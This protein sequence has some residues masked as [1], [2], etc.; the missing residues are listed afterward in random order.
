[1]L[2]PRGPFRT[3]TEQSRE[4]GR[5]GFTLV[6]LVI[7][8]GILG[9][10]LTIAIPNFMKLTFKSR[11]AEAYHV[12]HGIAVAQSA[13]HTEH[14][15]YAGTFDQLGTQVEGGQQLDPTTIQGPYYTYTLTG[16]TLSGVDN[17][18]YRV[19]AT[20]DIDPEDPVLD[21]IIIENQLTVIQ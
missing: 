19:T 21:V 18:N 10:I 12:L 15:I 16:L 5:E 13:Y 3:R 17:A 6:E 1:M 11:R 9:L 8:A 7:V 20:G 14:G 2:W 4:P